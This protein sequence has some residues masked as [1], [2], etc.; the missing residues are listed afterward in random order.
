[1]WT[2]MCNGVE[3]CP[4]RIDMGLLN[5]GA[6]GHLNFWSAA[7]WV[8]RHRLIG[9]P[10]YWH[11]FREDFWEQGRQGCCALPPSMPQT[12]TGFQIRRR[13]CL[14]WVQS[15]AQGQ[16]GNHQMPQKRTPTQEW[17]HGSPGNETWG[18]AFECSCTR[19]AGDR[20]VGAFTLGS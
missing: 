12:H 2:A 13:E 11:M 7:T 20:T 1:M 15:H 16:M 19:R 8:E 14:Q 10:R 4:V 6:V 5:P 17:C 3:I 9:V 18:P